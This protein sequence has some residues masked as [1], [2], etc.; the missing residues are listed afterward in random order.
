LA[1]E[2]PSQARFIGGLALAMMV[3]AI[4]FALFILIAANMTPQA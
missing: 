3:F 2:V 4:G 1:D